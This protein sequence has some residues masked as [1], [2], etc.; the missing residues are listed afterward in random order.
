MSIRE[1]SFFPQNH[2]K[3]RLLN[4]LKNA[5]FKV[6][7]KSSTISTLVKVELV[8]YSTSFISQNLLNFKF[9]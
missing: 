7:K 8:D 1:D 3:M 2:E 4:T 5:F 6:T 9:T